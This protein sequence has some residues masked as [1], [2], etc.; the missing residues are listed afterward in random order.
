[1]NSEGLSPSTIQR[2]FK[3]LKIKWDN[4]QE[5]HDAYAALQEGRVA[6]AEEGDPAMDN[7]WIQWIDELAE[8]YDKIEVV[9]DKKLDELT[10]LSIPLVQQQPPTLPIASES[11]TTTSRSWKIERVRYPPFEGNSRLYPQFKE[12]FRKHIASNC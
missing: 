7:Q 1:M 3:E 4:V 6:E 10:K 12:E 5:A 9:A 2:R 11:P 8:R